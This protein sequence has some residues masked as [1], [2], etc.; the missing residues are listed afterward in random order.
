V[1]GSCAAARNTDKVIES[2]LEFH[3]LDTESVSPATQQTMATTSRVPHPATPP[4]AADALAPRGS[5]STVWID[6][7]WG[8]RVSRACCAVTLTMPLPPASD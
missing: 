6:Y 3:F 7:R 2:L 1:E 8:E 5:Q 4:R